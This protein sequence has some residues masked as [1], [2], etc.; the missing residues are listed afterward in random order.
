MPSLSQDTLQR[1]AALAAAVGARFRDHGPVGRV[2]VYDRRGG[3]VAALEEM[4]G[5]QADDLDLVIIEA[6]DGLA[7][8]PPDFGALKA[9][10]GVHGM[11]VLIGR[12]PGDSLLARL[13]PG[14]RARAAYRLADRLEAAGLYL[15]SWRR[16]PWP[17]PPV[18]IASGYP[19][20]DRR[21]RDPIGRVARDYGALLPVVSGAPFGG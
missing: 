17:W 3:R 9:A 8:S 4:D 19:L 11:I 14:S 18:L 12:R 16:R 2:G 13:A 5:S 1:Y 10:L 15:H 20:D 7:A 21:P 6:R